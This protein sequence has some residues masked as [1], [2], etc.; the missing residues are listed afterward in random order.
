MEVQETD[1]SHAAYRDFVVLPD[2]F[3]GVCAEIQ[4]VVCSTPDAA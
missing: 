3:M 2:A 1:E 4:T